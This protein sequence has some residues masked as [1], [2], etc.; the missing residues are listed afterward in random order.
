LFVL[1][2]SVAAPT[3]PFAWTNGFSSVAEGC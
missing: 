2:G 1:L 3:F